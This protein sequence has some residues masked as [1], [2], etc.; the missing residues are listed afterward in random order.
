[1]VLQASNSDILE[2]Q[3]RFQRKFWRLA[4]WGRRLTGLSW[5][6][7]S[8]TLVLS[9]TLVSCNFG[10]QTQLSSEEK[11]DANAES[12]VLTIWWDQGYL[13]EEDE[14]IREIV[15]NW[16]QETGIEV[17]LSFETEDE[18]PA[19]AE[20]ALAGGN[21]PDVL[22]STRAEYELIPR[23]AWEGKL[24]DVSEVLEPVANLY[25][26]AILQ[27]VSL[28]DRTQNQ[29]SYYAVPIYQT[30]IYFHYWSDLIGQI[31]RNPSDIPRDWDGFW[32]FWQTAQDELRSAGESE[33]YGLGLTLSPKSSDTYHLFEQV[34]EA[35]NVELLD[36][37]GQL[38]VDDPQVRQGIIDSL[39]WITQLYEREYVPPGATEWLNPDNNFN[40]LN[41]AALSS[42]NP[43]LSI[44]AAQR[45]D[46]EVYFQKLQTVEF[47]AKPNGDPMRYL[48]S[49]RQAIVFENSK[50]A[51]KAKEF[52][53]YLVQPEVLDNYVKAALGRQFP[54]MKPS[55]E[56]PFWTDP[57]DPHIS[58]A[59]KMLSDGLTRPFYHT[60]NPAYSQVLSEHLWGNALERILLEGVSPETATDEAIDRMKQIFEEWE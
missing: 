60:Q 42:P 33:I 10:S 12:D 23:L 27:A 2:G 17:R 15:R 59:T 53:S 38:Q 52:L 45:Q 18:L 21:P 37:V 54:V 16:E 57:K 29:R 5:M 6:R 11:S 41:R 44:P 25:D 13:L 31:G 22:F 43:T 36:D 19:K 32:Q 51:E 1:M 4:L 24:A 55:Q 39:T 50:N 46:E 40:L 47:P 58:T 56:D 14:A 48:V 30:T 28:F 9:V 8:A 3:S 26:E 49:V 35:Y 20:R 7:T 34:L